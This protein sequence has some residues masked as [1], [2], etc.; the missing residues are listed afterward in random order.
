MFTGFSFNWESV[1][2]SATYVNKDAKDDAITWVSLFIKDFRTTWHALFKLNPITS[3][4]WDALKRTFS[5]AF[6]LIK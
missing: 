5:V 3:V 1:N 6:E 4:A 2:T